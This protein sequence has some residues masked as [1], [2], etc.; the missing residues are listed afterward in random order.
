MSKSLEGIILTW[1]KGAE[2]IYG[3]SAE[4]IRGRS[5]FLLVPPE[6]PND[7]VKILA[8]IANDE[9]VDH[10]ETVRMR[11]DG[12]R[13]DVALTIS[14]VKDATG[15]IVNAS[16]VAR[17]ITKRKRD[18][19]QRE[20]ALQALRE[21]EEKFR[22][23]IEQ[24][25]EGV[26]LLDEA[27]RVIE[28][29]QTQ[30]QITGIPRA[31]AINLSFE[32]IQYQVVPPDRRPPGAP[33]SFKLALWDTFQTGRPPQPNGPSEIE[34]QTTRGERRVVQQ[35]AFQ[36]KTA[37]GYRIGSVCRDITAYRQAEAKLRD[38][39]TRLRH[40]SRQ[41]LHVQETERRAIARELHDDIG[42]ALT[43]V[44]LDL[45]TAQRAADAETITTRLDDGLDV[46]EY[47][48][49][50]VRRLSL[51]LRPSLLDDLGLAAALR[52]YIDRQAQ[53][54]GL[55]VDVNLEMPPDRPSPEI[56]TICFR[57]AQEALN[58]TVQHAQAHRITVEL[59]QRQAGLELI[60]HDDGR[61]FDVET[62]REQALYG[63]SLGLLSME[64][65]VRLGNG[66]IE[67]ESAP[68]QGATIHV[69]LPLDDRLEERSVEA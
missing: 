18:E 1:N 7:M 60:I 59:R 33:E 43:A 8:Q 9:H 50:T 40:L 26:A 5:I 38:N 16:T 68:G 47:L 67:I 19:F 14:P 36:I 25:S 56:E 55:A 48:L 65:R 11:K 31:Q 69:W 17:D 63:N 35:T 44:K 62:A 49:Q 6:Y 10:Y 32:E 23:F 66:H 41:L 2:R 64:E 29:N 21:S 52:W 45:Q 53:R 34:I 51:D 58:N 27:G 13:I 22:S 54:A 46:I 39:Q 12:R 37:R 28:W 20:V 4:E 24:S 57:V 3:Y 61:G 30:E 15:R 42:Q